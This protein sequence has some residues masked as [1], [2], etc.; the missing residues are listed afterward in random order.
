M[1]QIGNLAYLGSASRFEQSDEP[2][3]DFD[4]FGFDE[5]KVPYLGPPTKFAAFKRLW[6]KNKQHPDFPWLY[7]TG[8]SCSFGN[9][10]LA[11]LTFKGTLEKQP[12]E[13]TG[14]DT[15]LQ[16]LQLKNDAG[17]TSAEYYGPVSW[18]K[19]VVHGE[20]PRRLEHKGQMHV[21]EFT[22]EIFNLRGPGNIRIAGGASGPSTVG[23]GLP[24]NAGDY[25]L[26]PRVVTSRFSCEQVGGC[27]Q[28]TEENEGRLE[29]PE[30]RPQ[31]G[32]R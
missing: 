5:Y 1:I 10:V 4:E 20:H 25:V 28:V 2:T 27:W 32:R 3:S 15:R 6:P 17:R 21:T 11:T 23:T 29:P 24:A 30:F 26:Q 14:S 12:H 19:Y 16:P 7:L 8:M 18:W 13:S 22:Y 9:M 31:I